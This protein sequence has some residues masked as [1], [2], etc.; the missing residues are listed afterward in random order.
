MNANFEF[1]SRELGDNGLKRSYTD[2]LIIGSGGAG[3]IAACEA[4]RQGVSVTVVSKGKPGR[5]GATVMAPGGVAAVCDL[6]CEKGDSPALHEREAYEGG[7]WLNNQELM[8]TVA[9]RA[10]EVLLRLE[11]MGSLWERTADGRQPKLKTDSGHSYNRSLLFEDRIGREMMRGLTGELARLSVPVLEE[12]MVTSLIKRGGRVAGALGFDVSTLETVVMECKCVLLATGGAGMVY[13]NTSNPADLTGD[14][15]LLALEAG[16]QLID[17]EFV[18]FFPIAMLFPESYK[19][20]L[21][22]TAMY[23]RLLNRQ[24]ERFMARYD[25][26][27]ME[28]S[29]RDRI[30]RAIMQ[31]VLEGCGTARGGVYSDCSHNEPGFF[32]DFLNYAY[33]LHMSVGIDMDKDIFETAPS[34]HFFMGG[35]RVNGKWQTRVPGLYCIGEA[36]GGVHGANRISQNALTDIVVSGVAAAE[37]AAREAGEVERIF[38]SPTCAKPLEHAI[39]SLLASKAGESPDEQREK[40]QRVM[41]EKAGV[42]R[43]G[44]SLQEAIGLIGQLAARPVH[45]ADKSRWI[46]QSVVRAFENRSLAITAQAV[47]LSALTRTESRGAH[48]R[49]DFPNPGE[50]WMRNVVLTKT[51]TGLRASTVPVAFPRMER[52]KTP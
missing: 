11:R 23:S 10:G 16:A 40:M 12:I 30:S 34:C 14:G 48:Y 24:G 8:G 50:N 21:C 7:E 6:W 19:G 43:S 32:R 26:A 45:L 42:I 5:S 37:S 4:A 25:P 41:W 9:G 52:G 15:F 35:V 18:Q 17:M 28:S 3:L 22:G 1:H 49:S 36:A 46:N 51:G 47:A 29:T 27:R 33:K 20:I 39:D 2:L 44:P 38:L 31:E 13:A